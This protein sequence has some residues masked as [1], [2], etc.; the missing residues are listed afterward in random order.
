MG[1]LSHETRKS[2][3]RYKSHWSSQVAAARAR[4]SDSKEDL[5]TFCCFFVRHE[6]RDCPRKKHDPEMERRVSLQPAHS[7]SEKPNK[8]SFELCG[9]YKPLAG[10]DLRYR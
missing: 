2:Q 1:G 9:N 10:H 6:I 8:P 5:V 4:Y 7:A 3:R